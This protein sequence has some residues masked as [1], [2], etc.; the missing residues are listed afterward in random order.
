MLFSVNFRPDLAVFAHRTGLPYA[1]WNVDNVAN[2][3]VCAAKYAFDETA[4]FSIDRPG[5]ACFRANGYKRLDHLPYGSNGRYFYPVVTG[6]SAYEFD[7]SFVGCSMV[8]QGNEYPGIL[9]RFKRQAREAKTEADRAGN[10]VVCAVLEG[11]V[12][13]GER[14]LFD[15]DVKALMEAAS[16]GLGFDLPRVVWNDPAFFHLVPGKEISSR[17]RLAVAG[18]LARRFPVDVFGDEGWRMVNA[19]HL[20]VH[21]QVDYYTRTADIYRR[22]KINLNIE[23]VYNTSSLNPRMIDIMSCDGFVMTEPVDE[24]AGQYV[25]GEDVVCFRSLPE[26]E[27]KAAYYLEHDEERQAI[28]RRG[29]EK[30]RRQ[31]A[32]HRQLSWLLERMGEGQNGLPGGE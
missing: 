27:E 31:H 23:K 13:E 6:A 28:A 17:K 18:A 9:E 19:P 16:R 20:R 7:I 26:L 10:E 14:G 22:S 30:A 15:C 8:R 24:L 5:L 3:A 2:S 11:I 21:G 4:I 25:D 12:R 32:M 29:G 1:A